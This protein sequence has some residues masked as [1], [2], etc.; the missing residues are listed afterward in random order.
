VRVARLV[1]D[2][3]VVAAI[4]VVAVLLQ[5]PIA[6]DFE[7]LGGAPDVVCV[8]VVSV[9]LMRG[10]EVG[11]I[12]GFGAGFLLDAL[13]GQPM[14]LSCFVLTAAGFA[15]G[16]FG[17][18][19]PERAAMRPLGAIAVL[20]VLTRIGM[21]VLGVVIGSDAGASQIVSIAVVPTAAFD[22]LIAIP[23]DP[24]VRRAL[25]APVP[26]PTTIAP[27]T[28]PESAPPALV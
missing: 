22:V 25:R 4:V 26:V 8:V 19:V 3:A 14:G 24:L 1:R 13:A 20:S 10:A 6:V 27:T 11:A 17:E 2:V 9:A 7:L 18:K 12:T 23:V 16:R 21:L 15:A 28:P 5:V